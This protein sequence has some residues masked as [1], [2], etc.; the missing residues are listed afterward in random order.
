MRWGDGKAVGGNPRRTRYGMKSAFPDSHYLVHA[1]WRLAGVYFT[2]DSSRVA[3]STKSILSFEH[4]FSIS[5]NAREAV[6]PSPYT[7][8][9]ELYLPHMDEQLQ[10]TSINS[11]SFSTRSLIRATLSVR[12]VI[13]SARTEIVGAKIAKLK[14]IN[15]AL[16]MVRPPV[17]SSEWSHAIVSQFK[18]PPTFY[19][20]FAQT[21]SRFKW[22]PRSLGARTLP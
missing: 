6:E 1:F 22:G 18:V 8:T 17:T 16:R 11:S 2:L 5:K 7:Y 3:T 21:D 4:C 19:G 12:S 9:N 10:C 13:S 15:G 14:K 20:R